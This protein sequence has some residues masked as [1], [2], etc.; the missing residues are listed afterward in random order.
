MLSIEK[1]NLQAGNFT[2]QDVS[3]K[4]ESNRFHV[5]LGM[6]GSGKTLLL[7]LLAG[8]LHADNGQI[9]LNGD[10]I[11]RQAPEQR[12]FSYLPQDNALFPHK[13]VY[14]NI[15]YGLQIQQQAP[16]QKNA[17][18]VTE[19]A[20]K[21][22]IS[23]LLT[24]G[25]EGLSG[26][27]QQR[28][29]LARALVVEKPFLLLDEPTSSLHETM[30]ENF[31]L[32]LKEIQQ[33]FKL[34]VLMTTHSKDS[35]F[36]LADELHF[37]NDGKISLSTQPRDLF[38]QP[39]PSPIAELLGISNMFRMQA[40]KGK[41]QHYYCA[42][43]AAELYFPNVLQTKNGDLMLGVKPVDIRIIKD[44]EK[45][46]NQVNSFEAQIEHILYK[47]VNA[48]VWLRVPQSGKLIKSELS[49]YNLNKLKMV[50]GKS[51]SCKIKE[52]YCYHLLN[53]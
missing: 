17:E 24:R 35:A 7:E 39:L 16:A 31:C 48:I 23:H 52:A 26:G 45:G 29:A 19:I 8:I 37:I 28:V 44:E 5:L 11:S 13:N 2:L 49:I 9:V 14:E 32:L 38:T 21:L 10:D 34:T 3:L 4:L 6:T 43:L 33:Q 30:Q 22:S 51:I 42:D 20:E 12:P 46:Q 1:I 25:I 27:E 36:L 50:Q 53:E 41:S 15:C 18:K 40:V 47:D